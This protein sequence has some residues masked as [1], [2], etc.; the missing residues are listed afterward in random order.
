MLRATTFRS[1]THAN[2]Y[3]KEA[4]GIGDY[5]QDEATLGL[6]GGALLSELG[7]ESGT[8]QKRDFEAL[9]KN[10]HPQTGEKLT[11]RD[12][13]KR[14][15]GVDFTFNPPKSFSLA[16]LEDAALENALKQAVND[17]MQHM[18]AF[19]R[20]HVRGKEASRV[21]ETREGSGL[22]WA[23]FHHFETRPMADGTC[24]PQ[25]H[26]H[27]YTFNLTKDVASDKWKAAEFGAIHSLLPYFE[28]RFHASLA[29]EVQKLGYGVRV[30]GRGGWELNG[31]QPETLLKFSRRAAEIEAEAKA[32]NI[33][34]KSLLDKL[35]ALTRRR[36]A[37][38]PLDKETQRAEWSS[39]LTSEETQALKNLKGQ[40][41][42]TLHG[43]PQAALDFALEH[44]LERTASADA[45][46]VRTT[47]LKQAIGV[48]S[49]EGLEKAFAKRNDL[50]FSAEG[51]TK[52]VTTEGVYAEERLAVDFARAG[53]WACK[54]L[55]YNTKTIESPQLLELLNSG[56]R[57]TVLEGLAGTG[58]TTLIKEAVK[59]IED[60]KN[61]VFLFAPTAEASRGVLVKEGFANAETLAKLLTDK[62]L[63]AQT[64]G[65]VLWVDEAG[66]MS[67]P[68]FYS[69]CK[70]AKENGNRIVLSG[71]AKQHASVQRG[72]PIEL[73]KTYA[74]LEPIRLTDIKRQTGEYREAV[75]SVVRGDLDKAFEKLERLGAFQE[76]DP[77]QGYEKVAKAYSLSL[78]SKQSVL[79]VCPTHKEGE[80]VTEAV[81]KELQRKGSLGTEEQAM[82]RLKAV[83]GTTAE[84]SQ[85]HFYKPQQVI[86]FTQNVKG[87]SRG[88]RGVV[89]GIENNQVKI[90]LF[91]GEEKTLPI[92]QPERF[93]V[94]EQKSL[95]LAVGDKL[96]ITQ[97][98]FVD[99]KRINNGAMHEVLAFDKMQQPILDTGI[100]LPRD[101]GHLNH[102]YVLTSH[103]AQG[104]TVDK[105]LLVQSSKSFSAASQNQFY[106]SVSRA[107]KQVQV[108]TDSKSE[109]LKAVREPEMRRLALA[110]N[111][112]PKPT[113]RQILKK[114]VQDIARRMS[115][116]RTRAQ[117]IA[118]AQQQT[119]TA[120]NHHYGNVR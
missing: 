53:V 4:L 77:K 63:Q 88:T 93:S 69:L 61:K 32:K 51:E 54:P 90:L 43:N 81:R 5:Y 92:N 99:G 23:S 19:V 31:L 30:D 75:K 80:A 27:V 96:R 21:R 89:T 66:L 33:T 46:H 117:H 114:T 48:A 82:L 14:R 118:R 40:P 35:G 102:S 25:H 97:N 44:H 60:T 6:W 62:N 10:R 49:P 87:F 3:F 36:K 67:N 110:L 71:D 73:L 29:H 18:E 119:Q 11:A 13:E 7:L 98:A 94:Y 52:L 95:K 100:K 116:Q 70:L 83:D 39:R 55:A 91:S 38:K 103:A 47:A 15:S 17:T 105:V 56:H 45:Y 107:R 42:Q 37:A 68:Q 28:A 1:A 111:P 16:A 76:L 26:I 2:R 59:H 58:K 120:L 112:R 22:V 74:G 106:V 50:L 57:I 12:G 84:K 8:V 65:A 34:D 113:L 108:F 86:Q 85:A 104:K 24:D 78:E 64:K 79:I 20:V 9:N 101:F 41:S 109:L 72:A 115:Y